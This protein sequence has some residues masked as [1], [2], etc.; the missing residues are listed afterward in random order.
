MNFHKVLLV[1]LAEQRINLLKIFLDNIILM[2][3][4]FF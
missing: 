3:E 4:F 1:G 2:I